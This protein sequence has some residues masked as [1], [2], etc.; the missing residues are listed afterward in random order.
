MSDR[1]IVRW[2]MQSGL[3]PGVLAARDPAVEGG[4]ADGAA[5]PDTAATTA[6]QVTDMPDAA[7]GS[8]RARLRKP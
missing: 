8:L 1:T 2:A 3:A 4:Q 5:G 6:A 7:G